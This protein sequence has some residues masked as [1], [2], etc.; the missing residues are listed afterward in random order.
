MTAP[1]GTTAPQSGTAPAG[2]INTSG[3][4]RSQT[5]KTNRRPGVVLSGQLQSGAVTPL[6]DTYIPPVT[7][8]R[9][10]KIEVTATTSGNSANVVFAADAPT[11]VFS[12][13]S[14]GDAAGNNYVGGLAGG[15]F[16]LNLASK[17]FFGKDAKSSP[18][19]SVTSGSGATGGSFAQVLTIPI[20]IVQRTGVGS[21]RATTTQSPLKLSLSLNMGSAI[22]STPPTTLP[23]VQAVVNFRGYWNQSGSPDSYAVPAGIGTVS[24]INAVNVPQQLSGSQD[25]NLPNLGLGS[26]WRGFLEVNRATSNGARSDA[27]FPSVSTIRYRGIELRTSSQLGWKDDMSDYWGYNSTTV[28]GPNG[29]D[30]GVY[31]HLFTDDFE[32]GQQAGGELGFAWL[33]TGTGDDFNVTATWP[34]QAT[35]EH[36][37]NYLAVAGD[38]SAI[39]GR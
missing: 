29:L 18:V 31:V 17:W 28:D 38:L 39:Q 2:G 23:T 30:Q 5:Q 8:I 20:E 7:L 36:M 33:Q 1:A 16:D 15:S 37:V 3:A 10:I 26:P 6:A 12:N 32:G 19:Y 14:F 11:N 27:A 35:L 25:F 9:G 22:Y 13:I 34:S 21:L 24:Y 4:F